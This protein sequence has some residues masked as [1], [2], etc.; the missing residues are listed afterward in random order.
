MKL[1]K[2]LNL[3]ILAIAVLCLGLFI[4]LQVNPFQADNRTRLAARGDETWQSLLETSRRKN[5]LVEDA[6]LPEIAANYFKKFYDKTLRLDGVFFDEYRFDTFGNVYF[7]QRFPASADFYMVY[8]K[9]P[10]AHA[11][12]PLIARLEAVLGPDRPGWTVLGD[13]LTA[14]TAD[15]GQNFVV[16]QARAVYQPGRYCLLIDRETVTLAGAEFLDKQVILKSRAR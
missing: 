9:T 14:S 7:Y 12:A 6:A 15:Q 2:K 4:F 3:L 10:A 1:G 13:I 16:V 11:L 5:N 8:L